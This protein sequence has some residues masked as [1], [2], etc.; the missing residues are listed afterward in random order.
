MSLNIAVVTKVPSGDEEWGNVALAGLDLLWATNEKNEH[1]IN[2]VVP[3]IDAL[4]EMLGDAGQAA[5]FLL[6][7]RAKVFELGE[8]LFLDEG[9]REIVGAGRK[10]DK[11]MIEIETVDTIEEAIALSQRVTKEEV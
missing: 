3:F 2:K 4:T 1:Y 7:M 9:G 8:I 11:W 6:N 5:G 10:P